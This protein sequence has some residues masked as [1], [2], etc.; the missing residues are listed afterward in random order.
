M[1]N[2]QEFAAKLSRAFGAYETVT[3]DKGELPIGMD[4]AEKAEDAMIGQLGPIG[5]W[6]LGATNAAALASTGLPRFFLG[7]LPA[8]R[9]SKSGGIVTGPWSGDIGVE[10]EYAF[11]FQRDLIPGAPVDSDTVKAA[12][13]G[14]HAAFEI[15][16]TRYSVGLGNYGGFATVADDG[17]AGWL[18]VGEEIARTGFENLR[19]NIVR[20]MEGDRALGE[21]SAATHIERFPYEL[22]TDF[23]RLALAR[24]HTIKAG[25]FVVP[26]SCTGYVKAPLGV[27]LTG[28][29]GGLGKV[30]AVFVARQGPK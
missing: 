8:A 20:F 26:G 18:V 27:P 12:I 17:A 9:V 13:G 1:L 10:C 14:V 22:L 19:E 2:V 3:V 28:D 25:Q 24:G 30:E 6:K 23:V 16:S 11:R 7:A 5:A 29:F 15:P 4:D 21:G